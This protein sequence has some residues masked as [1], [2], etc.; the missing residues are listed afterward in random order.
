MHLY[1]LS[2]IFAQLQADIEDADPETASTALAKINMIGDAFEDKAK[3][4]GFVIK[5]MQAMAEAIGKKPTPW[6]LAT[7]AMDARIA[8]IK[9]YLRT[10]MTLA[11]VSKI[12]CPSVQDFTEG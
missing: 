4:V 11:A 9:E 10:N 12:E 8:S 2:T 3:Q 1:E 7:K 5:N 6:P